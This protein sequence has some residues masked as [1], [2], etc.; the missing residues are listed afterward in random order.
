MLLGIEIILCSVWCCLIHFALVA[1]SSKWPTIPEAVVG[2]TNNRSV[3][4]KTANNGE[5]RA[6]TTFYVKLPMITEP[7]ELKIK[8]FSNT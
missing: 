8:N 7:E 5:E 6:G 3:P 1:M 2:L 4:Y